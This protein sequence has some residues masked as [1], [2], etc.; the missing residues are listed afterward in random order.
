MDFFLNILKEELNQSDK[1]L[2]EHIDYLQDEV[3]LRIALIRFELDE[4]NEKFK[5][6]LNDIKTKLKG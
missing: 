3:E 6:E 5:S 4:L 2:D 1:R